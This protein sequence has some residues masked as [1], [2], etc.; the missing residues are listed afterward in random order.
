[1]HKLCFTVQTLQFSSPVTLYVCR[2]Q[3]ANFS[4]LMVAKSGWVCCIP[5]DRQDKSAPKKL[6]RSEHF[7]HFFEKYNWEIHSWEIQLRNTGQACPEKLCIW[8]I[9][10][11]VY[12]RP[13]WSENMI[14]DVLVGYRLV[15]WMHLNLHSTV[16]IFYQPTLLWRRGENINLHQF[17]LETPASYWP[18]LILYLSFAFHPLYHILC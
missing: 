15:S 18:N 12:F 14:T 4:R 9:Q 7:S 2:F 10:A 11:S 6:C 3:R 17:W 1:M 13:F 8:Q 16:F 5:L